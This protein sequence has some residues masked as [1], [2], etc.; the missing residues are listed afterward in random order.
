MEE[1][2]RFRSPWKK[3]LWIL[4]L[5]AVTWAIWKWMKPTIYTIPVPE[6][7]A[8]ESLMPAVLLASDSLF[9]N[10][11]ML[12]CTIAW[13]SIT[14]SEGLTLSDKMALKNRGMVVKPSNAVFPLLFINYWKDGFA[15]RQVVT[16]DKS[17]GNSAKRIE[18]FSQNF[19]EKS[20]TFG[21]EGGKPYKII[22]LWQNFP[23]KGETNGKEIRVWIPAIA[24]QTEHSYIQLI[25]AD[26]VHC[27]SMQRIP[28]HRGRVITKELVTDNT[29]S[30]ESSAEAVASR[31]VQLFTSE[32]SQGDFLLLA[33]KDLFKKSELQTTIRFG[34]FR[35]TRPDSQTHAAVFNYFGKKVVILSNDSEISREINFPLKGDIKHSYS[36]HA[37]TLKGTRLQ[38]QIPAK[39]VEILF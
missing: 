10:E 2:N 39:G 21:L 4:P 7:M 34:D 14:T 8:C 1:V 13:D 27:S 6:K 15:Y 33:L 38:M 5:I 24:A 9:V 23:L 20:I 18:I 3:M 22:A 30:A 29:I 26:S 11:A 12:N 28:L 17:L 16:R 19:D 37:F 31:L 36:G 35:I 25:C 32:P